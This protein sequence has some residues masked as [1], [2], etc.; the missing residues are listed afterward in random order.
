MKAVDQTPQDAR[1]AWRLQRAIETASRRVSPE[2]VDAFEQA[3]VRS[4]G[5]TPPEGAMRSIERA[6]LR[7]DLHKEFTS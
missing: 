5:G 6:R 1:D 3:V 2:A 7:A 4:Y